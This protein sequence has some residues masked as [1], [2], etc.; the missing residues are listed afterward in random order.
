MTKFYEVWGDD[1]F[2][3]MDPEDPPYKIAEF[4]TEA[5]ALSFAKE[6]I[7]S[8]LPKDAIGEEGVKHWF[9]FG[10]DIFILSPSDKPEVNF[11][12]KKFIEEICTIRKKL[13]S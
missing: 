9:S 4:Q 7:L 5:E 10:E 13:S 6:R 2:H 8:S 12:G 3:Y 1:L 11:S